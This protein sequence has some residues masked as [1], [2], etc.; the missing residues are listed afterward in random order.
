[1]PS[2][3]QNLVPSLERIWT[4]NL[5]LQN[6]TFS[7]VNFYISRCNCQV[8]IAPASTL[9]NVG[10]K[11]NL[12]MHKLILTIRKRPTTWNID[13]WFN[14]STTI[15]DKV[16]PSSASN[17]T[18][19]RTKNKRRINILTVGLST[20]RKKKTGDGDRRTPG[21]EGR[22]R[23]ASSRDGAS[24]KPDTLPTPCRDARKRRFRS[25]SPGTDGTSAT[26]WGRRRQR[27]TVVRKRWISLVLRT[28]S[29]PIFIHASQLRKVISRSITTLW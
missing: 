13:M 11:S 17:R 24:Q 5:N 3:T 4:I 22:R 25:C 18:D 15:W 8:A 29:H 14:T 12:A 27:N 26:G 28:T 20:W 2:K 7:P 23:P 19:A 16:T 10:N 6:C 9:L 1:M 21:V